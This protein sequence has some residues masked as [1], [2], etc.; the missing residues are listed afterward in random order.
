MNLRV[1]HF[2]IFSVLL[3]SLV[4]LF[5][6]ASFTPEFFNSFRN[7]SLALTAIFA[8]MLIAKSFRDDVKQF[9]N[10]DSI[11]AWT[12]S[13]RIIFGVF[14][15]AYLKVML[16]NYLS[17]NVSFGDFGV[18]DHLIPNTATGKFMWSYACECNHFGVHPTPIMFFLY[19]FH[20]L[21]SS[22][23]FLLFLHSLIIWSAGFPLLKLCEKYKLNRV[24]SFFILISLFI[25]P[26]TSQVL[27]FN[28]H[29]EV[30]YIPVLLWL[31]Y[32][33]EKKNLIGTV[34]ITII[35]LS[36]K[37]DAAIYIGSIFVYQSIIS[38]GK[39]RAVNI[40]LFALSLLVFIFNFK[41]LIPLNK[42]SNS[43]VLLPG[44]ESSIQ[45]ILGSIFSN[46]LELI[47]SL[48]LGGH[49]KALIGMLF[50]P[51]LGWS[52]I[53][54][55][56][57]VIFVH[58]AFGNELMNNFGLY[59]SAPLIAPLFYLFIKKL[60]HYN[61]KKTKIIT[62][63]SLL[64]FALVGGGFFKF[65]PAIDFTEFRKAREVIT[66]GNENICVQPSYRPMIPYASKDNLEDFTKGCLEKAETKF[67]LLSK[68]IDTYP[69]SKEEIEKFI[70]KLETNPAFSK[71]MF[72]RHYLFSRN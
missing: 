59:Y 20:R 14:L 28:F 57:P 44:G 71:I 45:G 38:K 40:S 8:L 55:L 54:L 53:F 13:T 62:T 60:S 2:G 36:I 24:V 39:E 23:L 10:D 16:Q 17:F 58:Q 51:L 4:L 72:G 66:Y 69:Y 7:P 70:Q 6:G 34:L 63:I 48:F 19:P 15:F 33:L 3:F 11:E 64:Y 12:F 67:V 47:K 35:G 65:K 21:F 5:G 52:W 1:K 68:E 37:E 9:F 29:Y 43:P 41:Y 49:L 42:S 50:L 46:P 27:S 30:F 22:P 18:I 56:G 31:F 32:F 26:F 25:N 61:I